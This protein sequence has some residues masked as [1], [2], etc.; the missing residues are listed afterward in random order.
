MSAT[1]RRHYVVSPDGAYVSGYDTAPAAEA[2]AREYGDGAH[3]I[4]TA[5]PAYHP[6]AQHIDGG[7]L[8]F[9]GH[10][11]W[12][13]RIGLDRNLIQAV[14]TGH[15]P[16]VQA[17]L[18]KGA[19]V[20]AVDDNGGPVLVWAVAG[21]GAEAVRLLLEAGADVNAT[22]ADGMTALALSRRKGRTE[23]ADMLLAAGAR[24]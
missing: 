20:N 6:I 17:F 15:P 4:D 18:A 19:D 12:D 9:T 22:D 2:A 16:I 14:K 24:L 5:A 11:S 10:G 23:I 8:V 3:V 13:T 7:E 21:G 1:N